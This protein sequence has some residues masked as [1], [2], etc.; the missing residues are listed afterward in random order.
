VNSSEQK[1][2]YQTRWSQL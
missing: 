2:L 1:L